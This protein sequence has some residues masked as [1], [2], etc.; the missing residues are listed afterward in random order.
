MRKKKNQIVLNN[1]CN[2]ILLYTTP[3]GQVKV[4]IFLQDENIWLMQ[5]KIAE[6]FGVDRSV[7]TKHLQNIYETHELSKEATCAKNAQVQKEGQRNVT[8][9][10]QG[11]SLLGS[12]QGDRQYYSPGF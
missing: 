7:I 2:E 1:T 3:N 10:R 8:R 11:S 5:A 12:V 4:E 9:G 6:Q